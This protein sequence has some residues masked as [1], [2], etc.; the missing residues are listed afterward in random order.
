MPGVADQVLGA[1]GVPAILGGSRLDRICGDARFTTLDRLESYAAGTQYSGRGYDW[2][3]NIQGYG[4]VA[5]ISP[6]WYV[7]LDLRAP[8]TTMDVGK[9][10]VRRFTAMI[11]GEEGMPEITVEGDSAAEDYVKALALS[12][13]IYQRTQEARSKG[14]AIGT[15]VMSFGFVGGLPRVAVHNA[16]H[17]HVL[18]WSDRFEFRPA[19]VLECYRY[20]KTVWIAGGSSVEKDFFYA[21]YW[22]ETEEVLW[23]PIPAE[24]AKTPEWAAFTH[25]SVEHG[26]GECP[27]YWCQNLPNCECI[28][29]HADIEGLMGPIDSINKLLSATVKGTLA[30]VDPTLVI[31]DHPANN[32]GRVKKG[33][34]SAIYS[35]GGAEFLELKGDAVR[36]ALELVSKLLQYC[37][38]VAGVVLGDPNQAKGNAQSAA[39]LKMLYLPM[40][41]QADVL[42]SQYGNMIQAMLVGMLR[43]AKAIGSRV[44]G[45]VL[46]TENGERVQQKPS[47]MLPDRVEYNDDDENNDHGPVMVKRV[48]GTSEAVTLAWPPYFR[49]TTADIK[50]AVEAATLARGATVSDKTAIKF[51]ASYFGVVDVDRELSL[52]DAERDAKLESMAGPDLGLVAGP[53]AT[54]GNENDGEKLADT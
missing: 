4:A 13:K 44:P 17:M 14:G 38:D 15:A 16:K 19:E 49:A 34:G 2:D 32:T 41:Q 40:I 45:P 18:R 21:R 10:I 47:V 22:S 42:R 23:D 20:K 29:G 50:A 9:L 30:N 33:S 28:D 48:P 26:Y 12:S 5:D 24:V 35:P 6:G 43:A 31:R 36:T 3:G 51:T 52:I 53:T 39:A 46:V 27:V 8:S 37:L 54:D 7:P 11:F 1:L 25:S